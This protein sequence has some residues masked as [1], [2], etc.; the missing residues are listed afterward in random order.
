[1]VAGLENALSTVVGLRAKWP[2]A[3][4]LSRCGSKQA[5]ATTRIRTVPPR[6]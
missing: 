3:W 5:R 2:A 1:L 4:L 6:R